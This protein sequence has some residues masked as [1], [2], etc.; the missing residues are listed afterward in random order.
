MV[1]KPPDEYVIKTGPWPADR[2]AAGALPKVIAATGGALHGDL[3]PAASDLYDLGSAANKWE[4]LWV[5]DIAA[6]TLSPATGALVTC[7]TDLTPNASDTRDLGSSGAVWED[8]FVDDISI[9][10]ITG[11]AGKVDIDIDVLPDASGTRD[12]GESANSWRQ[13]YIRDIILQDAATDPTVNGELWLNGADVVTYSDGHI[14]NLTS[15]P[16]V[17]RKTADETVTSSTTL[18]DDDHLLFSIG[19]SEIWAVEVVLFYNASTTGDIRVGMSGP[20]GVTVHHGHLALTPAVTTWNGDVNAFAFMGGSGSD[21]LTGGGA[22]SDDVTFI[23][24]ALVVNGGTAG[25]MT[26]QWAQQSSHST[27]TI[28]RAN[29]YLIAHQVP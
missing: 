1:L 9:R 15:S 4:D 19:A 26:I 23:Y 22:G 6:E 10:T 12:L 7:H 5:D 29:S 11:P 13:L 24:K 14:K 16:L 3:L 27:G 2:D 20:S 21:S 18:Q 28:V 17:V 8:L 25:T